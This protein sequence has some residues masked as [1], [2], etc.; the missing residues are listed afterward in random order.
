MSKAK[1]S[2]HQVEI[3]N[4]RLKR[5]CVE[6]GVENVDMTSLLIDE[7]GQLDSSITYDGLHPRAN[8]FG[9]VANRLVK[10]LEDTMTN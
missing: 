7:E 9:K 4:I 1:R 8:G 2:E 6:M 5:V 3:Y 10:L